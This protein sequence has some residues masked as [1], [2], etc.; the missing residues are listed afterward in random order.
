MNTEN[1]EIH[2]NTPQVYSLDFIKKHYPQFMFG[3]NMEDVLG[4]NF[5]THEEHIRI[6]TLVEE[7]HPKTV[8]EFYDIAREVIIIPVMMVIQ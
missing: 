1:I 8:K 5:I 6:D 3:V 7:R 4:T 2:V